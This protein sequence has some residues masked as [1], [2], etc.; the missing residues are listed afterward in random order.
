VN[1]LRPRPYII[2]LFLPHMGCP[3]RC[4]FCN[5]TS[6]TG[7][8][9]GRLSLQQVR[10][11]IS[12]F[13]GFKGR[14]RGPVEVAFYGGNFL[15]LPESYREFLLNEAQRFVEK[16]QIN[17][18]R[19][20]TRPD[21]ITTDGLKA[22]APYTVRVVEVG[23]QSMDETVLSLSGR[24]HTAG[25][26]RKSV[27]LLK[28]RGLAV[29]LQIMPGLP[30]DTPESILETGRR[31]A[32]LKPDVVRIYP[33][34]VVRNTILEKWYQK[35]RFKPLS[36]ADAVRL[37]KRLY[38]LF[39]GHGISVIRMGLQATGSLLEPGA[40]VAGPFHPAF[41]HLVYSAVFLDTATRELERQQTASRKIALKVHPHDVPKMKGLKNYN[42]KQLIRRFELEELQVLSDLTV[43]ENS[44]R[45]V[46]L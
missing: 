32:E 27:K 38:L 34:V 46:E 5:Q 42:I 25:H 10:K 36:L 11:T 21:T 17:S 37:T 9:D 28:D 33:T 16:G 13:L 45:V 43:P 40:V 6:I 15:G 41:G 4:V 39:N 1:D 18:I 14:H 8:E 31:V 7:H 2:P 12:E 22:L 29:G 20:S 44:V 26:T 30:G 3:H 19:F 23:A 35:G 24:G